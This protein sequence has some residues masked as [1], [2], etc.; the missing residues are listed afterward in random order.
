MSEILYAIGEV[1][2]L[3]G[4]NPVTLRAW[5]R[6]YGLLQ[7]QRTSKGHRLYSEAEVARIRQI[8]TWLELGVSIGQVKGLLDQPEAVQ[9]SGGD[10]WQAWQARLDQALEGLSATRLAAALGELLSSYP[11]ALCR[12][13]VLQPWLAQLAQWQRPDAAALQAYA[14]Q[15]LCF[16]LGRRLVEPTKGRPLVLAGW[17]T[18]PPLTLIFAALELQQQGFAPTLLPVV[19]PAQARLLRPRL[20]GPWLV[21]VGT[22]L[23]TAQRS[24][25]WPVGCTLLGELLSLYPTTPWGAPQCGQLADWLAAEGVSEQEGQDA[26]GLV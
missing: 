9:V 6:R 23:P 15:W 5:Q 1:A 10:H 12:R 13:Q 8:L 18:L 3:T 19:T 24:E 11:F 20:P 22:G 25:P 14:L 21:W 17:G 7:P 16:Y 4:I 26:A 2:E